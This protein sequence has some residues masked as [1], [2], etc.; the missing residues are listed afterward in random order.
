MLGDC[1]VQNVAWR[2]SGG[3]CAG[4]LTLESAASLG[5]GGFAIDL[6][7]TGPS[8]V[9]DRSTGPN[10][11]LKIT[12]TFNNNITSVGGVAVT[13]GGVKN[14]TVDGNTVTVNQVGVPKGCNGSNN[15][16]TLTDVMDDQGNTVDATA[17]VGLLLGDANGDRV[18]DP[19]DRQYVKGFKGQNRQ[20]E[21][22]RGCE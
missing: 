1:K 22:P 20:H 8:G 21:L 3:S 7:L 15:D 5:R 12:M 9:E 18:V 13:C 17:T 2:D 14:I 10:G 4:N 16:V 11:K 6:P 19:A